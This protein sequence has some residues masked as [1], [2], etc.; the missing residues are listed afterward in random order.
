ML[1]ILPVSAYSESNN[2]YQLIGLKILEPNPTI[3]IMEPDET[4]QPRFWEV[5]FIDSIISASQEWV[6][7]MNR[8]GGNWDFNY[9]FHY[10]KDHEYRDTSYYKQC[11]VFVLFNDDVIRTELGSTGYDYSN[12]NHKY[13]IIII[14]TAIPVKQMDIS[15][16]DNTI[17]NNVDLKLCVINK[18]MLHEFG[19]VLGLGHY[20]NPYEKHSIMIPFLNYRECNE[21]RTITQVDID[22]LIMI[23]GSD[24]FEIRD[25]PIGLDRVV[26][27]E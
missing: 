7:T 9:E 20:Y 15:E 22:M 27:I 26:V 24:G 11:N 21:D 12:S 3:C 14:H 23:Y 19:H 10:W 17:V 8:Q 2:I 16:Y 13:A 18:I 25:N 4:I 6:T 5:G 1:V